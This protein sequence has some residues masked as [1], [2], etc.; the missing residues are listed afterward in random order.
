MKLQTFIASALLFSSL[1]NAQTSEDGNCLSAGKGCQVTTQ[2]CS[3]QNLACT[4]SVS[5]VINISSYCSIYASAH[6]TLADRFAQWRP[7]QVKPSEST[8]TSLRNQGQIKFALVT[9]RRLGLIL[10]AEVGFRM[11]FAWFIIDCCIFLMEYF[12]LLIRCYTIPWIRTVLIWIAKLAQK[13]TSVEAQRSRKFDRT[14][15]DQLDRT[16]G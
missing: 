9:P 6:S 7:S 1:A 4:N 13:M 14:S 15:Q 12:V 16:K 10:F 8:C 2:C 5:V 3:D 11:R